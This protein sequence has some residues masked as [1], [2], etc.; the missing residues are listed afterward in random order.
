MKT[1]NIHA[2]KTHLSRLVDDVAAGGE[3]IIAKH[4]KPMARLVPLD[5]PKPQRQLGLLAGQ[6]SIPDD[7]DD[8]LPDHILKLFLGEE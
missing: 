3:V 8:P 7:F 2:A 1:V 5:V 6:G 4:G